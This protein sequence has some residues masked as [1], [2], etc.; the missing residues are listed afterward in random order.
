M[1]TT[2]S[3]GC[4]KAEGNNLKHGKCY[5]RIN[6]IYRQMKRRCYSKNNPRYKDY[7]GRG[8]TICEEWQKS[9]ES[10]Y[11][12]SMNNGYSDDLTIDRIDNNRGYSPENCRWTDRKTQVRNT[13]RNI[14]L[15]VDGKT[16]SLGEW[17]E[18]T[19]IPYSVM[20]Q[21]I[22]KLGWKDEDAVKKETKKWKKCS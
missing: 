7:G 2:K 8:I 5:T 19:G 9:F 13:R 4:L 17:S 12:W 21:R 16:K 11:D 15:T 6:K 18:I 1:G 22:K 10:F 20:Y 3:C 14:Y